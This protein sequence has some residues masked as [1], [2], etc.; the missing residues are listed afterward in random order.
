MLRFGMRSIWLL[1]EAKNLWGS[2]KRQGFAA[3]NTTRRRGD[4][5]V[6]PRRARPCLPQRFNFADTKAKINERES[7]LMW[8]LTFDH[9]V[10][11]DRLEHQKMRS[12]LIL[13]NGKKRSRIKRY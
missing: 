9:I 11:M 4:F 3:K 10:Q 1:I 13:R 6:Q 2:L 7:E 12:Q 8:S 5:F